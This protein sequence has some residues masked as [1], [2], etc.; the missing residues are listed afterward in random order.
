MSGLPALPGILGCCSRSALLQQQKDFVVYGW[1]FDT[2]L[3][4]LRKVAHKYLLPPMYQKGNI[5]LVGQ[6]DKQTFALYDRGDQQLHIGLND[7]H[8]LQAS[9]LDKWMTS[10]CL[11][12]SIVLN[13][14]EL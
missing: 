2:I 5:L 14:I 13:K 1:S 12:L 6:F 9:H 11:Q 10:F 4:R 3:K 7:V 8:L